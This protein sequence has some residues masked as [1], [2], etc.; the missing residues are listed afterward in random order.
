MGGPLTNGS[1][2]DHGGGH[3]LGAGWRGRGG[4]AGRLGARPVGGAQRLATR[5]PA[6]AEVATLASPE[7]AAGGSDGP[8]AD[9]GGP[10]GGADGR[11]AGWGITAGLDPEMALLAEHLLK[12]LPADK[13][14]ETGPF[15]E[16]VSHLPPFFG[17]PGWVGD[18]ACSP[19][20]ERPRTYASPPPEHPQTIS[21]LD[22]PNPSSPAIQDPLSPQAPS[23]SPPDR[24]SQLLSASNKSYSPSLPGHPVLHLP[25]AQSSVSPH[26]S[27]A[28]VS[29]R[30]LLP[31]S[32]LPWLPQSAISPNTPYFPKWQFLQRLPASITPL[33]PQSL[34]SHTPSCPSAL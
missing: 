8:S 7:S 21:P 9:G 23:H 20:P 34:S 10:G 11:G 22:A 3:G 1:A 17:E 29:F 33:L 5:G 6:R 19:A 15:L 2:E 24:S 14:I 18:P 32:P 30:C 31:S 26:T 12:P 25:T 4:A 13:Q 27:H 16:A 28:T